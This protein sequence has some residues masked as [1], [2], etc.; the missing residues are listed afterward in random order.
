MNIVVWDKEYLSRETDDSVHTIV[1]VQADSQ[2]LIVFGV[3]L[4]NADWFV[5][6]NQIHTLFD[7]ERKQ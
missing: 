6:S 2:I 4:T 5:A 3:P 1:L 7:Y